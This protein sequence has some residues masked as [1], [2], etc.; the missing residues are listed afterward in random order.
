MT[1][2]P[3]LKLGIRVSEYNLRLWLIALHGKEL[4]SLE[5]SSYLFSIVSNISNCSFNNFMFS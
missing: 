4:N 1:P 3:V 2:V 5:L